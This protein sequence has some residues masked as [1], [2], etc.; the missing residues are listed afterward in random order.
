M[1][2]RIIVTIDKELKAK[3]RDRGFNSDTDLGTYVAYMM[4]AVMAIVSYTLN[5]M[6]SVVD[7]NGLS[8]EKQNNR[9]FIK[10]C[11][12]GIIEKI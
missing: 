11:L 5:V 4:G 10:G 2:K 6:D 8:E 7:K 9:E 1:E 12:N 3:V